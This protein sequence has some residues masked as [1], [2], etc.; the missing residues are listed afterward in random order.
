LLNEWT[1]QKMKKHD[2]EKFWRWLRDYS[3]KNIKKCYMNRVKF[4]S[5]CG[6]CNTWE[7]EMGGWQ[8]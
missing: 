7:S 6:Q 3:S 2:M 4:D 1:Q 5:R 8:K